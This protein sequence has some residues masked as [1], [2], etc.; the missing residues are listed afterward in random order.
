MDGANYDPLTCIT[1]LASKMNKLPVLAKTDVAT[2]E[3]GM[4]P[5]LIMLRSPSPAAAAAYQDQEVI[6]PTQHFN[7]QA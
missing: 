6:D 5:F 4:Q 3:L 7:L 2:D 1:L